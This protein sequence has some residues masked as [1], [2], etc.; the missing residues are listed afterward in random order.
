MLYSCHK[1]NY[2]YEEGLACAYCLHTHELSINWALSHRCCCDGSVGVFLETTFD[3]CPVHTG[4][5]HPVVSTR[6]DADIHNSGHQ[7]NW[8]RPAGECYCPGLQNFANKERLEVTER[9][10]KLRPATAVVEVLPSLEC[11]SEKCRVRNVNTWR[12]M[13]LCYVLNVSTLGWAQNMC[14]MSMSQC[15]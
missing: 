7:P 11:Q 5:P 15:H 14:V 8:L 3:K 2:P 13:S 6:A 10:I 9:L 12:T 1:R 4:D